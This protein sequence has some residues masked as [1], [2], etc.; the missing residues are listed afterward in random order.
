MKRKVR[1][2]EW[3][4]GVVSCQIF[5]VDFYQA[6]IGLKTWREIGIL[7]FYLA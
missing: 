4:F 7:D 5:S 1:S 3:S 2:E 6:K